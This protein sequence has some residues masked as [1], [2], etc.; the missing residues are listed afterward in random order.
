MKFHM[1]SCQVTERTYKGIPEKIRGVAWC[2]M[3]NIKNVKEKNQGVYEVSL[4]L[5][6]Y[7][8]LYASI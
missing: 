3:L 4:F 1:S 5:K 6:K 2:L 8:L 7:F